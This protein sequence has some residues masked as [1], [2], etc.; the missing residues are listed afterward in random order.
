MRRSPRR[1]EG[2][3]IRFLRRALL[4]WSRRAGRHFWWRNQKDP[5]RI[6]LVEILLRQTRATTTEQAIAGFVSRYSSPDKLVQA[7]MSELAQDLRPFGLHAQRAEQ[8]QALGE[9]LR[10]RGG[11]I[12]SV[13]EDL[14]QLPGIGPYTAAAIRCFALG[15]QEALIDV[16]IARI[17]Q[18]VFNIQIAQGEPRRHREIWRLVTL[19]AKSSYP[20]EINWAML[21][22]GAL[23]CMPRKPKCAICPLLR[24]CAWGQRQCAKG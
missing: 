13:R 16:N 8:L 12:P 1:T 17:V 2:E 23:I 15:K 5:Y 10:E 24:I 18:R 22:L 7:S 3:M 4:A 20:R 19:L 6:A 11:R 21:D 9:A 14:L